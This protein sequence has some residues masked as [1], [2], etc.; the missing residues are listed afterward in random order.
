MSTPGSYSEEEFLNGLHQ[1]D[2]SCF[3][4]LYDNYSAALLGVIFNIVKDTD[5]AESVLQDSFIKIWKNLDQFDPSKGRLFTWLLTISRNT[6]LDYLRKRGTSPL[7]EI[8]KELQDVYSI[9]DT[10]KDTLIRN[11]VIKLEKEYRDVIKLIY[12]FG[13]TQQETAEILK[14]PLGTVKTR[15][16]TALL[17]LRKKFNPA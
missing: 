12:F 15:T 6:A 16:R 8:Q 3:S 4:L 7:V 9:S 13:Y 10:V 17:Q 5:E 14:I 1:R 2:R 11:E